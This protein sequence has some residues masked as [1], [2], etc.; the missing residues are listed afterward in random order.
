M[1][2]SDFLSW[3]YLTIS[4]PSERNPRA[5]VCVCLFFCAHAPYKMPQSVIHTSNVRANKGYNGTVA[6]VC[7]CVCV[8]FFF[9]CP[10]L[11]R[12][13]SRIKMLT[14]SSLQLLYKHL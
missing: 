10:Q 5:C 1:V 7:V 14:S 4:S 3:M 9:V 11:D 8:C 13:G 2:V 6:F 12:E